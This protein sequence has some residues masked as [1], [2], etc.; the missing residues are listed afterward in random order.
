MQQAAAVALWYT[1]GM[2][3]ENSWD[4]YEKLLAV[5]SGLSSKVRDAVLPLL[6]KASS[7]GLD[8]WGASGDATFGIDTVAEK[9]VADFLHENEGFAIYTEDRG[10]VAKGSPEYLFVIDPIDGTRPAAAGLESCCVSIAL[11]PY[12]PGAERCLTISDVFIGQVREIKN[13]VCYTALRGAGARFEPTALKPSLSRKTDLE[14]LFWTMGFRGRPAE[15]LITVLAGL[16]DMS[17]VSG[18]VFDLGSA[19]FCIARVVTGEMDSYVDVG[20]RLASDNPR[21]MELFLEIGRGAVLNNYPYDVAAA[22]LIANECGASVSDAYGRP[23]DD[24]PLI[25]S[26]G[27]GQ[28][29][30][31]VSGNDTMHALVLDQVERGMSR[32]AA[33]YPVKR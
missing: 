18:G 9:V 17:S 25:P 24:Y 27:G 28:L 10:L 6:G 22:A 29:S 2:E 13:D 7:K 31:V 23:L 5:V 16:I 19:T 12:E 30:A 4:D 15:P 20:Q 1:A 33:R 14:T 26:G 11:S 21:V 32:L 8:G 3:A